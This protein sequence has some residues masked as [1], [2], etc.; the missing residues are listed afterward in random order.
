MSERALIELLYGQGTHANT[1]TCVQDVQLE[2]AG[3]RADNFPH[4]I[5]Q[6]VNHMNFWMA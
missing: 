3:R 1:L 6:L 4:S 5:W 2:L